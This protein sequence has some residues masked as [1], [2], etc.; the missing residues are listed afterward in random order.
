MQKRMRFFSRSITALAL[1][2]ALSL[3]SAGLASASWHH[4]NGLA[5][6]NAASGRVS[7]FD[8]AHLGLGGFVTAVSATSLTV[9]LWNGTSATYTI[10]PTATYTEGGSPATASSLVTGDRVQLQVSPSDPTTVDAI[11]I[12]LAMLFGTVTSVSGDT[13]LVRDF[14]GFTRTILVSVNT[15][16]TQGGA[17][18]GLNDVLTG[19]KIVA[20]GTVDANGTSLD[21]LAINIGSVG[22]NECIRGVITAVTSSSVTVQSKDGTTTVLT[23]TTTTLYKDGR[24][25]LS[26]AD[27]AVGEHVSVEV[28]STAPTTALRVDICLVRVDGVVSSVTSDTVVV[29]SFQGFQRTILLGT[30]TL[31][32]EGNGPG[33][34]TD[35]VVGAHI[36]ALGT[37]D[38][39]GTS[40]DAVVVVIGNQIATPLPQPQIPDTH[41][42]VGGLGHG[43]GHHPLPAQGGSSG[44]GH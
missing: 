38:V 20:W 42:N 30:N 9:S 19:S 27:L 39:D 16:Y 12:E 7:P 8:Y 15:K 33:S 13:I 18:A 41:V 21:A 4:G 24:Y 31:Y 36:K 10:S 3:G 34:I 2:T 32:F 43:R 11:N 37:V 28:N 40:L 25:T 1:G 14:Q 29:T 17:P 23:L 22:N 6:G 5:D 26:V 44:W 35:V